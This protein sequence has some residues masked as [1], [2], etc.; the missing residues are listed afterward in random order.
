MLGYKDVGV[1][2][3][4]SEYKRVHSPIFYALQH[5]KGGHDS[6]EELSDGRFKLLGY[7]PECPF[8]ELEGPRSNL[9][10]FARGHL[11]TSI[12]TIAHSIQW[13]I[14]YPDIRIVIHAATDDKGKD[15]LGAIKR[16]FTDNQMFRFYFPEFCPKQHPK[17]GKVEDIGN[18]QEFTVPNRIT[19][20]AEPTVSMLTLGSMVAGGHYEVSKIDDLVDKENIKTVDQIQSVKNHF[21]ALDPLVE[22]FTKPD[23]WPAEKPFNNR[24]WQDI[25]GTIYHFNDLHWSIYEAE[26]E[27]PVEKRSWNVVHVNPAP[28]YPLGPTLWPQRWPIEEFQKIE[29]DPAAGPS[30][31]YAQYF[32]N[33]IPAKSGLVESEEEICWIN[34]SD[35]DP[36]L[37]RLTQQV[38]ID[39]AGMEV[40]RK[41][42]DT[43][44]TVI[45]H[46]GFSRD[47]RIYVNRLWRERFTDPQQVINLM[48]N[49]YRDYPRTTVFK[50]S[51]DHFARV[52]LPFLTKEMQKRGKFIPVT[53]V[54]IDN[55]VSKTQKILGLKPWFKMR[56]IYWASDVSCGKTA[57][58]NEI[59]RFPK[60]H[61]DILDTVCDS[62]IQ[63]D[64]S[65]NM[66]VA[67]RPKT[68]EEVE[69]QGSP[70]PLE[71]TWA[72]MEQDRKEEQQQ[73][74]LTTGW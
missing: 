34:R 4:L 24:G 67:G 39:L 54:P 56:S 19:P 53:P 73:Y 9:I 69:T 37:P 7:K 48:F 35:L 68:L 12:V 2:S 36:L 20:A 18:Q 26:R 15:F 50:I 16:H 23:D 41:H 28:N 43:D 1:L 71:M 66:A 64:G 57:V 17:T 29:Q 11:K 5:F 49:I 8:T 59:M 51:K 30:V 13:I 58:I 44:Y 47:G 27:K 22:R 63:E 25:S 52:L 31:L 3:G 42:N 55:Q 61:D 62:L 46:H 74:C 32:L 72:M 40:S 21:G 70:L 33:P 60:Y 10:L 45:N 6:V 65:L 38:T 14:N